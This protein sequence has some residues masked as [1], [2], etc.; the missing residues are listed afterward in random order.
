MELHPFQPFVPNGS[1][2]LILGSFPGKESTQTVRADDWFYGA[3]RN[4]FWKILEIVFNQKL[5]SKKDKQELFRQNKIAI[6]DIILSCE[7]GKNTNLDS[8]LINKTYN[9]DAVNEIVAR[10]PIEKILFTSKG[11]QREFL[12]HFEIPQKIELI[13]LPS[14]S[15]IYR[16]LSLGEKAEEY[17][18]ILISRKKMIAQKDL[19]FDKKHL[20]HPYTSLNQPLPVYPV[21]SA[22]GVRIQLTSGQEL[23]DGM[24][25]W[26]SVI[27]G[28]NHPILNQAAKN[29]IDKMSHVMFGGLTHQPAIDLG[30]KLIELLP[31]GLDRIFL[32]DS[33]SVSVEVAMKMAVQYQ[34]SLGQKHK[35]KFLTFE[36][37]YHGDTAG[38]MSVCDPVSGMHHLFQDFMPKHHFL[39]APKQ[40]F[41]QTE[42]PEKEV[43]EIE[44]FFEKYA[45]ESVAFILEPV[46][47]G[48]GGM[49]IYSPE[50]LKIIRRLCTEYG[51]LLIADEIATGFGRTGKM[52]AVEHADI[53][54]DILCVGKALTGGYMTLAAAICTEKVA[55]TICS[56]EA[57]VMMHGPTFMGNPLACAVAH[58]SL[59]LLANSP[60][61][62]RILN[63]QNILNE[64]LKIAKNYDSVADVRVLGA[65]GV[66]EN[67]LNVD[68]AKIQAFF[69]KNGVWVRPFRN[70]IY[71]MPPYVISNEDLVYLCE[72]VVA[73]C[74]L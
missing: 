34:Q 40:P 20:W 13:A 33:G 67:K 27:H 65:I 9:Q 4:Q 29:Q 32:C 18:R 42:I 61:Q 51:L 48:A 60:W 72:A 52:F 54:P 25:S 56:G 8:N 31:K 6:T 22:N 74:K 30:K 62:E 66:I 64:K 73:S 10:N 36:K 1:R 49:R 68:V 45:Q 21:A 70:L 11:V 63:I 23:I 55:N 47:Q 35:S 12:E 59:E 58:A 5:S 16:K 24:S 7:R 14:P 37:G 46:V 26:W 39:A 3:T 44:S 28:Y 15:P 19:D 2:I 71:I 69:V 41:E 43:K 53:Q 38:A 17:K 50:Y 57:G